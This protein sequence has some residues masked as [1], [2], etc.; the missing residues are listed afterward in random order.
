MTHGNKGS[1]ERQLEVLWTSGT[2]TGLNDSQLLCRF[3]DVRD[4]TA[5]S[6]FKELVDRHG[7]MVMGVCRHILRHTHDA[8]DAFQATFLV[9]VRKARSVQVRETLAPWLY[10]VAI[11][12]AQ[13]ARAS[14]ARY[15][16]DGGE[17]ME[18]LETVPEDSDELELR[19]FLHEELDRLPYKYRAP[20]VLCHL[21][22]K[23][24]EQAAQ[25][26]HWPIGT[27]SGRLSRGRELLKSRLQRRGLA[28]PPAILSASSLNLAKSVPVP[29]VES[30]LAAATR[31]ATAQSVSTSVLGLTHG[32]L[33]TMFLSKVKTVCLALLLFAAVTGGVGVWARWMPV[34][35]GQPVQ[36]ERTG[37][38][39][40]QKE[41]I[42]PDPAGT[43]Q[44]LDERDWVVN[45]LSSKNDPIAA[46]QQVFPL[47]STDI[48]ALAYTGK[49]VGTVTAYS[50]YT[51]EWHSYKLVNPVQG[52]IN[53]T[54]GPESAVYQVGN[55]FY[56]FSAVAGKWGLLRL[57]ADPK[58]RATVSQKFIQVQQGDR[59]YV[60]GVRPG[61]W[62]QGVTSRSMENPN[63]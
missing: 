20:I 58:A 15:R 35:A 63:R 25:L 27:V 61:K 10:S 62:S 13:R 14:A 23:T 59:L 36:D 40:V 22:G 1:V 16:G 7:P 57:P 24:H 18:A 5:D 39:A 53:P 31:F 38:P 26:L 21:E 9:L 46:G 28:A 6:A 11:R 37:A 41:V 2:L 51:G 56:A 52:G 4:V 19:A 44:I 47:V 29:L 33:R 30:T 34:A 12:T 60:F 32:V 17:Q 3:T 8:D 55:D 42:P 49:T 54:I 43:Q 50:A 48:I 45:P